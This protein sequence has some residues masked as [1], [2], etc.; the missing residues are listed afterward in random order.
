M[1]LDA[2]W[3]DVQINGTTIGEDT[4]INFVSTPDVVIATNS[5]EAEGTE[6]DEIGFCIAWYNLETSA[7][8]VVAPNAIN[9]QV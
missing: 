4:N 5:V 8:E 7:T 6:L 2:I 9:Y 3:R 1:T